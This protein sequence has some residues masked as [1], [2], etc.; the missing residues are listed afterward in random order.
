VKAGIVLFHHTKAEL[1]QKA[2]ARAYH[3]SQPYVARLL[4]R[5]KMLGVENALGPQAYELYCNGRE[6]A[7]REHFEAVGGPPPLVNENLSYFKSSELIGESF[8]Q[9]QPSIPVD[10]V[11]PPE[12]QPEEIPTTWVAPAAAKV[13]EEPK[14]DSEYIELARSTT[15]EVFEL[16][17][18][19][20]DKPDCNAPVYVPRLHTLTPKGIVA[21]GPGLNIADQC[22]SFGRR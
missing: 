2:I 6:V 17:N 15:G 12:D 21:L 11:P 14:D 8:A 7:R 13:D 10:W 1:P 3:V 20:P 4:A 18:S 5:V 22:P 16:H 9:P 19:K